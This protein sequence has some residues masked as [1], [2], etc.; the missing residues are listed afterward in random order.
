MASNINNNKRSTQVEGGNSGEGSSWGSKR[1]RFGDSNSRSNLEEI[2]DS[3]LLETRKTRRGAVTIVEGEESSDEEGE[4][5]KKKKKLFVD[6]LDPE[7]EDGNGAA[8]GGDD[9]I[10]MFGD[11]EEIARKDVIKKR[12]EA[13]KNKHKTRAFD[14]SEIDGQDLNL[15]ELDEDD[16]DSDG[17]LKIEAFNMK[18]ELEEGGEIDKSGN[19]I[20]KLDPERFHDNWLEG[21]SKK[22]IQQA[23]LAHER[24]NKRAEQEEKEAA[25]NDMSET[26]IFIELVNILKPSE[27]VVGALQRL[28]GGKKA[29]NKA[30]KPN[31]KKSWQKN[32]MD[33]DIQETAAVG[34]ESEE[35]KARKL[36][37]EKL[38][39]LCDKM[40]AKGHFEIYEGTYEQFV[41]NLRRADVIPDDWEIG[42]PVLR[43][44]EQPPAA[45]EDDPLLSLTTSWEY[46]WA[47]P[48]DSQ[49]TDKVYGPYSGADMKSWRDQGFFSQGILVRM[50]GDATFESDSAVSFE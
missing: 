33:E 49:E 1:I 11:P 34:Q 46:K 44:G 4:F 42:T 19:F 16:Y 14:K 28:G 15:D 31:R 27:T 9:E 22:Q 7:A 21:V 18:E 5:I 50:V 45:L 26:D 17:N 23:R 39:D 48:S 10:D 32:K 20:R 25:A 41:R 2:D 38:T 12:K 43:P 24:R 30:S 3:D 36:A 29:G 35:D 8:G 37:I 6:D 13:L 40:M 47:N